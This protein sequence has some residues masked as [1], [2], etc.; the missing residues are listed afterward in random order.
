MTLQEAQQLAVMANQP[1]S[2]LFIEWSTIRQ[3]PNGDYSVVIEPVQGEQ[4][5][6]SDAREAHWAM[7]RLM[8]E[9]SKTNDRY[10]TLSEDGVPKECDLETW[11]KDWSNREKTR[12]KITCSREIE[13]DISF[14]GHAWSIIHMDED[15]KLWS[16]SFCITTKNEH[17]GGIAFSSFEQAKTFVDRYISKGCPASGL[18][19]LQFLAEY[20][21]EH[22]MPP[23][24]AIE[25]ADH[26]PRRGWQRKYSEA[27]AQKCIENPDRIIKSSDKG[28]R[29]GFIWK[30]QK[31][32]GGKT[33]QIV[34]EVYKNRCY[35]ITGY[36][37]Q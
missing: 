14:F 25:F 13:A 33:L 11:E 20:D 21:V 26:L 7:V 35:A 9:A 17:Y 30:F 27:Q 6:F 2:K 29:G 24:D 23:F 5:S 22:N 18:P 12:V 36:W 19:F 10:F 32:Y 34:A 37:L 1:T 15:L 3:E 28:N 16:A 4:Q 31:S 8:A